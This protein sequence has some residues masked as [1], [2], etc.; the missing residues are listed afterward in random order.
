MTKVTGRADQ[1]MVRAGQVRGLDRLGNVAADEA[2]DFGRR[3]VDHTVVDARR[4]L[5]D[6][7]R[8]WYP[9]VLEL[10]RFYL[11]CRSHS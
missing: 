10:H 3:R 7:C 11:S 4:N 2:A 1:E 9:I 6:V 8:G 5:S